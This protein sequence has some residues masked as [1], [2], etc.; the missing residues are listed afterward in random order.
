MKKQ[1]TTTFIIIAIIIILIAGIAI[2]KYTMAKQTPNP[3][4]VLETSQGN[5]TLELNAA[6]APVTVA[7]FMSYVKDGTY[8]GTVFHRVI[9]GFMIQGG[10]FSVDGNEKPTKAPIKI[11]SDNGLSNDIGTIAMARTSDPNSATDQFFI[12]TNDNS[13]LNKES[14]SDGYGYAVFGKVISGMDVVKKIEKAN[15]TI[16]FRMEDW[17]VS[18][19]VIKKVDI[20]SS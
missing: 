9:A 4:V 19:V 5:I 7:N 13:F 16:K 10:G 18:D 6:K 14:S 11:E 15:T 12:N 8:N 17:P 20:K 2:Y 3:V 1:L